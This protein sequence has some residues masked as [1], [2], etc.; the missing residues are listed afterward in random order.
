MSNVDSEDR[1]I[2]LHRLATIGFVQSFGSQRE[3]FYYR[4]D[5]SEESLRF[6]VSEFVDRMK[7]SRQEMLELLPPSIEQGFNDYR[8]KVKAESFKKLAPHI[9]DGFYKKIHFLR[10]ILTLP[11]YSWNGE[12]YDITVMLGPLIEAFAREAKEF[13]KM[14]VIKRGTSFM[15]IKFANR[16]L[17]KRKPE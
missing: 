5:M 11:V 9:K 17:Q 7:A 10:K 1:D 2:S 15:E 3:F 8:E 12:T 6:L 13:Q 14:S 16:E 4:R